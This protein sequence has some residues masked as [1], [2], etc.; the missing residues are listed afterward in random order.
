M[1]MAAFMLISCGSKKPVKKEIG[2]QLYSMRSAFSKCEGNYMPILQDL[3][4]WGYTFVEPANYNQGKGLFYGSTPEEFK[5]NLESVGLRALS[6]HTTRNLTAEEIANHDFSAGLE[7]WKKAIADHKAAGMEYI[8]TPSIPFPSTL[9]ELKVVCEYMNEVGKLCAESGIK[10]GYHNH[11]GECYHL[12]DKVMLQF[13]LENTDPQYVFFELDV[14]WAVMGQAS[15]VEY[16]KKYPGR[17]RLLHI[18]DRCTLGDSGMVGFDAIFNNK[19]LAGVE[20]IIVEVECDPYPSVENSAKYLLN[21][22]FV[23]ASYGK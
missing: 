10:Y 18:K 21:A 3:A 22:P 7:W 6:S 2:I 16:F 14:Y 1:T 17:F 4:N 13:M 15:P 8:V 12:E 20:N 23:P 19:E 5:K 11:S 9:A